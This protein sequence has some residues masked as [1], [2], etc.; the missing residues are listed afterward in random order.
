MPL[1]RSI[2]PTCEGGG[3]HRRKSEANVAAALTT[4]TSLPEGAGC[5]TRLAPQARRSNCPYI[6]RNLRSGNRGNGALT[7]TV[8]VGLAS[9]SSIRF[10]RRSKRLSKTAFVHNGSSNQLWA[11]IRDSGH[12]RSHSRCQGQAWISVY[13]LKSLQAHCVRG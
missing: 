13:R 5:L 4:S 2:T 9:I 6:L 11:F 7:S 3:T 10:S 1:N 8:G 12:H